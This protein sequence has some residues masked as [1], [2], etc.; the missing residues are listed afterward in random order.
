[1]A[2]GRQLEY[3]GRNDH[4]VKIR[5]FRIELGE[6]E[7][8]LARHE[9]LQEAVVL[10]RED[11][12]GEKRLVAYV[13]AR[14]SGET[15]SA[16]DLRAYLKATLPE[17]MVPALF[18]TLERLP[19]TPNGKVDRGALPT[20]QTDAYRSCEYEP[21]RGEVEE[22]LAGIWCALLQVERVGR[23]DNFF[24]LG[25]HS[26]LIVQ[27]LD[28]LR[29]VGL[30]ADMRRVFE[31]PTLQDLASA[32]TSQARE[33]HEVPPNRIP[34]GCD[35]ITP[36]MLPLVELEPEHLDLIA[37]SAP[38]GVAN[39]QDIYP[40]V[41]LQEGILFHHLLDQRG[42]TYVL[43]AAL[44]LLSRERLDELVAALQAVVER[45]DVLRTAVLWVDL[46]RPVQV[47]LRKV[48]MPVSEVA[49]DPQRPVA[50]QIQEWLKPE[51]QRMDL[52]RAP[53]LQL[54]I[55]ADPHTSRWYALLQLHHMVIDHVTLELLTAEIVAVL[56]GRSSEL[57][58]PVPYRE[59]VARALAYART[60]D[61]ADFF[62]SRLADIDEPTAPFG[63]L[64]VYGDGTQVEEACEQLDAQLAQRI[65]AQ[66]R[67]LGVST[68]AL[69]HVAWGMVV[70]HTS[71]RDDVVFGSLLLGRL[72]G[73]AGAERMLGV[74]INTLPLRMRLQDTTARD[75]VERTQREIVELLGHEQAS[76]A[77]AQR[78]SSVAGSAPLFT[79]LLNYRH[80]VSTLEAQWSTA[81]AVR[82][83]AL[84][85]R[86]NYPVTLSVDDLG[87][88]FTLNAQT[89]R[90]IDPRRLTSYVRTAISSL[91]DALEQEASTP[92]LALTVL[93]DSERRLL[94]ESF[95]ATRVPYQLD[96]SI[97]RL[98]EAQA[99]R[100]PDIIAVLFEDQ[101]LTYR[102]LNARANQL[103]RHL[104]ANAVTPDGLVGICVERSVEMVVGLLGIL[105]AGAA[106]VP[107][108]PGY[109]PER[110]AYMLED[111]RPAVLLTQERLRA[112]LPQTTARVMCLDADW[113]AIA[114]HATDDLDTQAVA[115][116][117]HHLAYV[118]YTSGSTGRP[119]G[120]MNEHRALVNRLQWMQDAYRL[121]ESDRVLQKTPFSFDVSVWEFFWTLMSGARL[122]V[123]RPQGH[124]DPDYLR[125][126][127][128]QHGITTAH[129]VPSM[130]Q[131]FLERLQRGQCA[132]LRHVV[133]S[134]EELPAT[135]QSRFFSRLPGA[136]L[137]NLYGPTE[138]AVD[139]TA[140]E[141]N[142]D[143][144]A[145]H[146]P[147]GRP[148][149]NTQM[150]VLD[151]RGQ[152]APLGVAAE[153]HIGGAGV[154]R[155]YLRQP[156][157]TAERFVPDPFSAEPHAR[158][159]KTG[160]LGR[161]RVDGALE[162]LGRND[163]QVKIR[164]LRIE[165]GE[166]E[167][168]LA[169]QE[170]VRE[171]AVLARE[172]APGEK[173][174]VA[175]V[176]PSDLSGVPSAE[177]LRA[178]LK[179]LLPDYMVPSAFV[180][181]EH[182]PLSPNGKLDRRALPAPQLG[183]YA[184][185]QYEPP[186]GEVEE[187][188]AA[189]WRSLLRQERVGRRDNFFEL[190]GHSLLVVQLMERLRRVGLSTD[191]RRVFNSATLAD[192]ALALRGAGV[193]QV[194]APANLIVAGCEAITPEM[195]PLVDLRP[196]QIA[197]IVRA[198]P[199]GA[200]NVQ[201]IYPLA[202]LQ[203]G[204][205]FHHLLNKGGGD[206][207][208]VPMVL[209]VC[210]RKRLDGFIAALQC[211]IDRHDILRSAVL[212]EHSSTAVQVVLRHATV[213]VEEI[214]LDPQREVAE[215]LQGW[216]TP[217]RQQLDLRQAPL[218]RLQ[219]AADPH[220]EQWHAVLRL[221]HIVGDSTSHE[222]IAS[223]VVTCLQGRAY[224][225][226]ESVP[227]RNHV[228]QAL[229]Y[230]GSNDVEAFFRS[231][232]A[233]I[234]APTAPF[235]V[236]DVHGDGSRI[237][238][239]QLPLDDMLGQRVRTQAQRLG[240]TAATVFHAAW[241]L[242]VARTSGRDDVVFGTV[243]L[244][245]LH[246]DA[247]AQRILGM[248]INTLPL[249]LQ[250]QDVTV[251]ELIEQTQ[252]EL[253]E[254]LS[255]EQASLALAQRCSGL[256]GSMPLFT[257]LFNYRHGIPN[258]EAHWSAAS[259]IQVLGTRDRT[260][261]PIAV[262]VDDLGDR[263]VL[264]A[265][266]DR[267]ISPN[268][269]T[270]CL[271]E[272]LHALV[273][274]L[275]EAPR[276]P[277]LSLDVL[278]ASQRRQLIE[279]FNDTER[280]QPHEG[281]IHVF[282]ERQAKLA[283]EALAL[284]FDGQTLTYA[285]LNS[286]ANQLAH[287]LREQE[288]GP[289]DL[290]GLCLGRGLEMLIGVL[291]TWKAG[292]A[293]VPL[294]PGYPTERLQYML[295]DARPRVVLTQERM[296]QRLPRSSARIIAVDS[297]W[298]H[299]IAG[300]PAAD[301]DV[302]E[303]CLSTDHLAYVIYTSGSTGLPKGVMIEHRSVLNLWSGLEQLYP[304]A[305]RGGRAALNASFSFDASVQ[306]FVHLLSGRS[307]FIVPHEVR[308]DAALLRRFVEEH[309]I[310]A[311][312]CT[313]SQLKG[314]LAAGLFDGRSN[315][316]R[317]VLVG[318]EAIDVELWRDLARCPDTDFYN[319]YGPTECTVDATAALLK[320]DET[321][322]HLGRPML[323]RRVHILDRHDQ[324]APIGVTGEIHI[325]GTGVGRGYLNRPDLTAGRFVDEP[326]AIGRRSRMYRT[327]DLGRW[328]AD[329]VIEYLGRNDDQVK[330]RGF[331]IELGEI[332]AQLL[333]HE[334]VGDAVVVAHEITAG[335]KRL[336]AYVV[337]TSPNRVPSVESLRDHLQGVLPQ[338]MVPGAFVVMERWPLTGSGKVDRR[339]LPTPQLTDYAA[340][341]LYEAP[342][343]ETEHTL[344]AIWQQVLAVEQVGREDN[345]FD[346]GGH[347]LL[348]MQVL[349]RLQSA[350]NIELPMRL[351]FELPTVR[352]L[353]AG[354]EELGRAQVEELVEQVSSM[355]E[356]EVQELMHGL[357]TERVR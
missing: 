287:C 216:L 206:V 5:G 129:F 323:N 188:I 54:Q 299:L 270:A 236:L 177:E 65:R 58:R 53:L 50:E 353:S 160:D 168:Q 333:R 304:P 4:Q 292:G 231:K 272:A 327:G 24:E 119:K 121:G 44:E 301:P 285:Q 305:I 249:R 186:Q 72:H 324:L 114:E 234:D 6:I 41:P 128:E 165:L 103:A 2:R 256:A 1:M 138:A 325:A 102:D 265:Q 46:P 130:L 308:L 33:S 212:W 68:A 132:S 70:A 322:P 267:R 319:V 161:W 158:L 84:H 282:F 247:G 283:P 105:K 166:I 250:L 235:D 101:A 9:Q 261:Y 10:A 316:P 309:A 154:G 222:I 194:A 276:T 141:C 8:H 302:R 92:I 226:A 45:H 140:W 243:L 19:L 110:L 179:R 124:Q 93:P 244:G 317:V 278:P 142:S 106:Y 281:P 241:A 257:S 51:R 280:A 76:L 355:S 258:P 127:I 61:A 290:V 94:L 229:A 162:Y 55:A 230:A 180:T 62:R 56:E 100:T 343:G 237:E 334:H 228:A 225:L 202:P 252:R 123:A 48:S 284:V 171:A 182:L 349:A 306:Q 195:L 208:V 120:A 315:A 223:E 88:G 122:I 67:G 340:A 176:V 175:Y 314:W 98:F 297:E 214:A 357:T 277:A 246:G 26:L 21:P 348:A 187:I 296:L 167:A 181:L 242:V 71:G 307:L 320:G 251:R 144:D 178:S 328:R 329:G 7:S 97:H 146:V 185:R 199:G 42:D 201:D 16:E 125:G 91:V 12:P 342:R 193:Q 135:L 49:L 337:P 60:H 205:L 217:E 197:A 200:A 211:V 159:Y 134:G 147:I 245:R 207:Y 356:G 15:P 196:E 115:L 22:I 43:P 331:R 295:S 254:L 198:V 190:G 80:S 149:A 279:E 294:D 347:S 47:V 95:N 350:L 31:N 273:E 30:S 27:V 264:T 266:T 52:R 74:F 271:H 78:C 184:S 163:H 269:L 326:S 116:R 170:G 82:M 321:S 203:E 75:I 286:R 137:S 204:I 293:Y 69:F 113:Q 341:V 133:C 32:V 34:T 220:N 112:G 318:G 345:F 143:A 164:G 310:E 259:G 288:I 13:V 156:E 39:I 66:A 173:Q 262:S 354:I 248:F 118:I 240:V 77:V 104:R 189:I 20:P 174:L 86:T 330:V 346:L 11:S 28:R 191:M 139:V 336:V 255:H 89:D 25:G 215:Q 224:E 63:L 238:E 148:I 233:A 169:S 35:E 210:S 111:A 275:A 303:R 36:D 40:L 136:V 64:D 213:P 14:E 268:R 59:H 339:A 79:A 85:E 107:L 155:G 338:Y 300:R 332:E 38:G 253:V 153:I 312:D 99:A 352:E 109:P 145:R 37:R 87:A 192:L 274:A 150:Y 96:Q 183:A 227:Y 90:R 313:P 157:L 335:D 344:A 126:V 260:N 291:A 17:H 3:L 73:A 108:D 218:L 83:L 351:V 81:Q 131:I 232:L 151:R 117:S 311:I 239:V 209:S 18:V 289:D 23:R 298:Q 263:F 221:H 172:D 152:P 29:R 57:P 219:I